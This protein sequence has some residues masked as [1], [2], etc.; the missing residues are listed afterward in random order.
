MQAPNE[1]VDKGRPG[2]DQATDEQGD[3]HLEA[4]RRVHNAQNEP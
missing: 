2:E 1:G 4:T 3:D